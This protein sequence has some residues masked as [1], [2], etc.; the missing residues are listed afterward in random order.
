M[1]EPLRNDN[2]ETPHLGWE[3]VNFVQEVLWWSTSFC[4]GFLGALLEVSFNSEC[5]GIQ[6]T[7][8]RTDQISE[9]SH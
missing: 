9:I 3:E 1:E 2:L 5:R 4:I 8:K 6:S 7:A